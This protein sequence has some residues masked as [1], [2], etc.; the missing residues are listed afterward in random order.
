M[1]WMRNLGLRLTLVLGFVL[2]SVIGLLVYLLAVYH[3]TELMNEISFSTHRLAATVEA[4]FGYDMLNHNWQE[5]KRSIDAI[6]KQKGIENIRIFSKVGKIVFSSDE[7]E[8]GTL[9]DK[10]TE[11]CYQCHD[12]K[13]PLVNLKPLL[14]SR[15]F[16][17]LRGQRILAVIEAIHNKDA[18]AGAACHAPPQKQRI[19]GILDIAVSLVDMDD[20]LARSGVVMIIG[21]CLFVLSICS[22]VGLLIY[23]FVRRPIKRLLEGINKV[24]KG[25]FDY[26]L[27][28][29]SSDEIGQLTIA[30]NEMTDKLSYHIKKL[31]EKQEQLLHS[32]KLASLGKMAA[33]VAHE[34]NSPLTV[35]LNDSSLLI[36]DFPD[37][38]PEKKD[39]EVIMGEAKR[40]G[41]IIHNLLEFTRLER[42][43]KKLKNINTVAKEALELI[44]HQ[45]IL[46]NIDVT[47]NLTPD[48]PRI[49]IDDNQIKQV[50]LDIMSNSIQAMPEGGHLTISSNL[51]QEP[52]FL[53][54]NFGD[55]GCGIS[56]DNMNKIF[57]PFYTTKDAK[58][59]TGLGLA[60]C[61][62]II[63]EHGGKIKV[64]S[65]VGKGTTFSIKLPITQVNE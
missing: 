1:F 27:A 18:C 58:N 40:C 62:E 38:S 24:A 35:I 21:S 16:Y 28:V 15:V 32:Q 56:E 7:S 5:I 17:N 47:L 65:T 44:K 12:A 6:G 51:S 13:T 37:G 31:T 41:E 55:T 19:L 46:N 52:N 50:F 45:A 43:A 9:V 3:R 49:R 23:R 30:Y 54:V 53:D 39:L 22:L 57:Q 64:K 61:Y 10:K 8:I 4:R 33:G 29:T 20:R 11:A 34:L 59:G 60:I 2:S 42:P 26:S 25:D 48:M 63:Q 36:R 14:G